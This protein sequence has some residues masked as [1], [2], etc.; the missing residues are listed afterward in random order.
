MKKHVN[1]TVL[2]RVQGVAFRY[3]A[4]EKAQDMGIT[5]FARNMNDGSVYL[6]IEGE[7]EDLEQFLKWCQEGPTLAEVEKVEVSE[8][9]LKN[10]P[11]FKIY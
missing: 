9:N 5:G 11:D 1:V 7:E 3:R 2:G 6:E 4:L 8:S 10:Y